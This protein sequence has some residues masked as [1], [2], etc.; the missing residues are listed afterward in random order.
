MEKITAYK[1][2]DGEIFEDVD[3]A[4]EH[5]KVLRFRAAVQQLA[6]DVTSDSHAQEL[7]SNLFFEHTEQVR[8]VLGMLD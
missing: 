2:L 8:E 3:L 7:I 1:T 5:E 4:E 6:E